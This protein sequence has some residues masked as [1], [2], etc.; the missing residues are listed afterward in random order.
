[1]TSDD[2][3]PSSD[4]QSDDLRVDSSESEDESEATAVTVPDNLTAQQLR[5]MLK[6]SQ[7]QYQKLAQKYKGLKINLD[8]MATSRKSTKTVRT[9]GGSSLSGESKEISLAGGRFSVVGELWVSK[10]T[11]DI[12]FPQGFDPLNPNRYSDPRA[13]ARGVIAEL[14]LDLAPHLQQSLADPNRRETFKTIF[15][16]QLNQERANSVHLV[17]TFAG[18]LLNVDPTFFMKTFDRKN[19]P[20]L[21]RLLENPEKPGTRFPIWPRL[22]FP[23]HDTSST[24]PLQCEPIVRFLKLILYGPSSLDGSEDVG[25]RKRS[26]KGVLWSVGKTTPGMI[27]MAATLLIYACSEDRSFS[28]TEG[29]SGVNWDQRFKLYKQAILRFPD[30]Y[31]A[32]LFAWFDMRVFAKASTVSSSGSGSLHQGLEDVE[33]LVERLHQAEV[34]SIT[35]NPPTSSSPVQDMETDELI[36]VTDADAHESCHEQNVVVQPERRSRRS[37]RKPKTKKAAKK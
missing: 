10:T 18:T 23:N 14:Y 3:S 32:D 35:S 13:E 25:G 6:T 8:E 20:A 31:R 12:P 21:R 28:K 15:F 27:A 36:S 34:T 9:A 7:I 37:T 22:L 33:D 26:T 1:M 24:R 4:S 5:D 30:N 17:R 11:L 19:A 16:R 29:A 2:E